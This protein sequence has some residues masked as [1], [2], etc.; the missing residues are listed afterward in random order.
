M[1]HA[2]RIMLAALLLGTNALAQEEAPIP[3]ARVRWEASI[4]PA[5]WFASAGGSLKLPGAGGS[6]KTQLSA[7][8]MERTHLTPTGEINLRR[9][10]WGAHVRGFAFST[11]NTATGTLGAPIGDVV[12]TGS[13]SLESTLDLSAFEIEG[14]YRL[15]RVDRSPRDGGGHKL[16]VDFDL[17]FG[18]RLY[19]V[20]WVVNRLTAGPSPSMDR[21]SE[22]FLEPLL[23]AKLSMEILEQF[24]IDVQLTGGGLPIGDHSSISLDIMAGFAWRP[25]ENV[26]VQAGYRQLAFQLEDGSGT[27]E[28][29]YWGA[30]A[31]L[32]FGVKFL[33]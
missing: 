30:V 24:D 31:G 16:H 14:T 4:E 20:D 33:F 7:M 3:E 22:T 28:F 2:H 32:Y 19:D 5:A 21:T 18:A 10:D 29:R 25:I 12:L 15:W 26:G 9:G 6:G 27:E 8:N 23:G 11:T 1:K 13:D 17:V